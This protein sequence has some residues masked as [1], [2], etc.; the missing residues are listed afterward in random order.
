MAT[1]RPPFRSCRG[2]RGG[3][4]KGTS[5]RSAAIAGAAILLASC[6]AEP[7]PQ[8]SSRSQGQQAKLPE[9]SGPPVVQQAEKADNKGQGALGWQASGNALRLAAPEGTL[10]MGLTCSGGKITAHVPGFTPIGSE[11]RFSLGIGAEP[12]TLVA[13]L[14]GRQ[15]RG[16]RA[17]GA[18]PPNFAALISGSGPITAQYGAQKLGPYPPPGREI[19]SRFRC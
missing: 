6:G 12:V 11:D 15:D 8:E 16:V 5:F 13:D 2:M 3:T 1:E 10:L 9:P 14:E 7:A 18:A 17:E 4:M 19:L